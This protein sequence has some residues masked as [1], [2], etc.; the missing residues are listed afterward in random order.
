MK[1]SNR[2]R[3]GFKRDLGSRSSLLSDLVIA[4]R[5]LADQDVVDGYGHVSVRHPAEPNHFFISRWLAPELVTT[6]DIVELNFDCNPVNGDKRKLYSER[7]IHSEIYRLRP[8]VQSIVHTHAPSVV[9]MGVCREPL[10][11]IYHMAGFI[12]AGV[13]VF[14]IRK[15]SG[16]TNMLI[17]DAD[18][19]KALARALGSASGS[20]MRGHGGVTVGS[21]LSQAVGRSV[22]LKI[23]AELQSRVLGRDIASLA[24]EEALLA[25]S[26]NQNFPKDWDLWKRKV[27]ATM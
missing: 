27:M 1:H 20:L 10:V 4:N 25:D 14:D 12:G 16:M 17:N 18:R 11:P 22:Y 13:P 23:N 7:F 21:C 6:D 8:D 24:P 3:T 9:L 2:R 5:I 19:G 26:G 15:S